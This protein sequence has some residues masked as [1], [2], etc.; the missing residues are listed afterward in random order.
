MI[1]SITT[2]IAIA[3]ALSSWAAFNKSEMMDSWIFWPYKV[4]KNGEWYRLLS[5]GFVHADLM[6]LLFN[7]IAF[8]S[9]GNFVEY[10]FGEYFGGTGTTV[11]VL[12]YVSAIVLADAYNLFKQKENYYY[13]SLGAS[14]GVAAIIFAYVLIDPS[15][16]I[17]LYFIQDVPAWIFGIL[18][19]LYSAYMANRG[20]D[21]VG[22][23]AHFTG[24]IY[25]FAFMAIA[26]P[27]LLVQLFYFIVG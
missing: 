14:G 7:L 20:T 27:K 3:T 10:K 6:H 4:W 8:Y 16:T 19:L 9:F 12:F 5:C 25:G 26:Q 22:H 13:R 2:L 11:F 18:Y 1:F 15:G 21:N 24:A 17:T 23:I